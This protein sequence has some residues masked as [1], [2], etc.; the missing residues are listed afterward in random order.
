MLKIAAKYNGIIA[1]CLV[2]LFC[3]T[4]AVSQES[5]AAASSATAAID[6]TRSKIKFINNGFENASPFNWEID[7]SGNIVIGLVY[8]HER[9]SLN[10]ANQ[11]W[12]FQVQGVKGSDLTFIIKNFDNLW[13]GQ[14]A[15]PISDKTPCYV[16]IDGKN[17]ELIK[18]EL[19]ADN[20]LKFRVHLNTENLYVASLEPY[21][22]SDLDNLLNEIKKN[23]NVEIKTVGKTSEG[24]SLEMIRIGNPNSQHNIF[25]RARAHGFEVGGNWVVQGLVKSLLQKDGATYLNKYCV[26]IL[27]MANKDAVALGRT[28]FNG[29]GMDLNRNWDKPANPEISPEN[30]AVETWIKQMIAKGKKPDLAID[31]HNDRE[32]NL[33]FSHPGPNGNAYLSNTERF[34]SLLY[35]YTSFTE[36]RK[37][38]EFRN[39]GTIGEGL[40]ERY[41]I[42]AFIFE[43][44]FEWS[45]GLK[46][47]PSGKDWEQ[48]GKQLREVFFQYF[49]PDSYREK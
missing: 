48:L 38:E 3:A 12:H 11:H 21:R 43:L 35:K 30:Y 26:Y 49:N 18:T 14:K 22:I 19:L 46:K 9:S 36:G 47:V 45:A 39:P 33:H 24:R 5:T 7:S 13:N 10:R 1:G 25:L 41:G 4:Q 16:S 17:W 6:S 44:N 27:P 20:T 31:L 42:T 34:E 29:R 15:Y 40:L 23:P 28:R 2:I 37:R 32:G 8:D